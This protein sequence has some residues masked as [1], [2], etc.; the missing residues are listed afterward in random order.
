MNRIDPPKQRQALIQRVERRMTC[1]G[2]MALPAVPSLVDDYTMRC[3]QLFAALGRH[4][5]ESERLHLK[6]TLLSQLTEA[7]NRSQRS[8][9]VVTY[10]AT[11]GAPLSYHIAPYYPSIEQIYQDWIN[12]R[13]PP[14]FGTEPDAKV[15]NL[16]ENF[17]SRSDCRVL[18]IGA[19]T[20]RNALALARLG[21]PVDAVELTPKFADILN[22]S[23][24]NESLSVR[25]IC[26]DFFTLSN[27]LD[28]AYQLIFLSEVVSDFRTTAQLR[29]LFE[30]AAQ[31]LTTGGKL[32][33]NIFTPEPHYCADDAAREFAQLVYSSYFSLDEI[34]AALNGLPLELESNE[35]VYDYEQNHLPPGAWPPTSWYSEWTSGLDIFEL[36]REDSP[37]TFRWLVFSKIK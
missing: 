8:S 13:Q 20:G 34:T 30:L 37:I 23:A 32:L 31:R 26:K 1:E 16:V 6:Q 3:A 33:L 10:Q 5:N 14:Y 24:R 27:E 25:V 2:K 15:L 21:H 12:T 28:A 35:S 4:L 29:A 36:K 17:D 7:F 11:V 9:I 22:E 18:D 19:G